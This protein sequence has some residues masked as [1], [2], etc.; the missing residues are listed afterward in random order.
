MSSSVI[1]HLREQF[2]PDPRTVL[3]YFFFSFSDPNKQ[4]VDGML[5]SLLRQ[6]CA[7]RPDTPECI[8]NLAKYKERGERPDTETL[9]KAVLAATHGFSGV[10]I[11]ID[12]LDECPS[13][14]GERGKLLTNLSRIIATM[15]DNIHILCTSRAESDILVAMRDCLSRP[16]R[17][18]IDLTIYRDS[19]NR[20]IALYVDMT[21]T[22]APFKSWPIDLKEDA[23]ESLLR[24]ADGM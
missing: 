12:A 9:G 6:I 3:A 8:L 5:A 22:T 7:S 15:S 4:K 18:E 1:K 23:K 20:D 16:S 21:L 19:L 13:V 11:V 24:N 17:S 2:E 10:F 14:T